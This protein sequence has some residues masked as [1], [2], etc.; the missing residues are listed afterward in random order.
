MT[1]R[2][3]GTDLRGEGVVAK[4]PSGGFILYTWEQEVIPRRKPSRVG[5]CRKVGF[6]NLRK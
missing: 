1:E 4:D 2:N 5:S 6:L 3:L